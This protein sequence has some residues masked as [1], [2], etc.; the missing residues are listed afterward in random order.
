MEWLQSE[1]IY[2]VTKQLLDN[3]IE[4]LFTLASDVIEAFS[5]PIEVAAGIYIALMGY[6]LSTGIISMSQRDVATRFAKVIGILVLLETFQRFGIGVFSKIW[7]QPDNLADYFAEA[8]APILGFTGALDID[9]LDALAATYTLFAASLG[10]K[11]TQAHDNQAIWGVGTWV[12]TMAPFALT[13][14]TI[15]LAKFISAVLFLISPLVFILSLTFGTYQG[16]NILLSWFKAIL[17]TFLTVI[18]VYIVGIIGMT[19]IVK[20]MGALLGVGA[21]SDFI[22]DFTGTDPFGDTYTI[23]HLGPLVVLGLFTIILLS[24]ATSV[25]AALLGTTGINNQQATGFVQIGALQAAS[26]SRGL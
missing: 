1:F 7:E 11:V 21:I 25:A 16:T 22:S 13:V 6:S 14:I 20:Y 15:Y 26:A 18:V 5:L 19:M 9:T 17:M 8:L 23:V 4:Q 2:T 12:I 24:Q 3:S 10:E